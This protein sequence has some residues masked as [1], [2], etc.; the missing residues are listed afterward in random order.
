MEA[1]LRNKPRRFNVGERIYIYVKGQWIDGLIN[2]INVGDR[3]KFP[4]RI[5]L[6]DGKELHVPADGPSHIRRVKPATNVNGNNQIGFVRVVDIV[7]SEVDA[8]GFHEVLIED[9]TRKP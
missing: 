5:K 4:Y 2:G 1:N 7:S 9:K 3:A 6:D 8:C